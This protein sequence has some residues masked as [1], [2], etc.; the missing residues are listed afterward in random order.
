[1]PRAGSRAYRRRLRPLRHP[2]TIALRRRLNYPSQRRASSPTPAATVRDKPSTPA[3]VEAR[4]VEWPGFRGPN[5]DGV[6]PRRR[7]RDR[8]VEGAAG[9]IVAAADRPRLVV[10][11]GAGRSVYTQEQRGDDEI[12]S[13][14]SL[15]T[16][17]PV[18][19]HGTRRGS[20][21]RTA[22]PVRAGR[23]R[24][25]AAASTRS[26]ATGIVNALDAAQRRSRCGRAT[27]RPT[28]ARRI[29]DWG[30]PS[31]PL[32][33]DDLVI[34]AASGTAG[35]VRHRRPASRAGSAR[36]AGGATARRTWRRS[37]ASQQILLLSG[38]GA[39]SVE[40]AD[41]SVLWEHEWDGVPHRAAGA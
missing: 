4:A 33:V 39:T 5:R 34:V 37:T 26:G 27:P 22:A 28:P 36:T 7:D 25:A 20:T 8:L 2:R 23:R 12:V 10:V 17:E 15:A 32:V 13:C 35:G 30:F 40:P 16:G 24:S 21:S 6:V 19:R 9:R 3:A 41:G 38:T 11:R 18:W 1:M 14:Y 29:P 31:S